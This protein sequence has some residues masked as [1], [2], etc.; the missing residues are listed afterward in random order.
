MKDASK[1]WLQGKISRGCK[2][3]WKIGQFRRE[4]YTERE[5]YTIRNEGWQFVEPKGYGYHGPINKS[6]NQ[7]DL[8]K[9][10]EQA[11]Q[12]R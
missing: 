6:P 1:K 12:I 2:T 5:N 8:H 4:N 3:L 11:R 7:N 10:A 9:K